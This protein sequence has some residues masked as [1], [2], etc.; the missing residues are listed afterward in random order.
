MEK[1]TSKEAQ[2]LIDAVNDG[3]A[4]PLET[5]A[6]FKEMIDIYTQ[7]SASIKS[8]ALVEAEKYGKEG[9]KMC[10]YHVTVRNTGD[11]LDYGKDFVYDRLTQDLKNR[12]ALLKLASK[13]GAEIFDEDGDKIDKVPV[14]TVGG[15]VLNFKYIG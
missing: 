2:A 13:E 15:E 14:K 1:E 5:L 7:A 9:V 3:F 8:A 6:S 10:G 12:A 4:C 11:R